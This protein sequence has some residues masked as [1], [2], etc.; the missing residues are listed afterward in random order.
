M[1]IKVN[2][3]YA[4]ATPFI[5][6]NGVYKQAAA[7][8][9]DGGVYQTTILADPPLFTQVQDV[10]VTEELGASAT[11]STTATYLG[12]GPIY[13]QWEF[14]VDIAGGWI[15]LSDISTSITGAQTDTVSYLSL[16]LSNDG[17]QVRC[18]ITADNHTV[19]TNAATLTVLQGTNVLR[20]STNQIDSNNDGFVDIWE[21]DYGRQDLQTNGITAVGS[22]N[23]HDT[24]IGSGTNY[25]TAIQDIQFSTPVTLHAVC[26]FDVL[27]GGFLLDAKQSTNNAFRIGSD[28]LGNFLIGKD[29]NEITI[30]GDLNWHV[31]TL[32]L[33]NGGTTVLID[34]VV[35]GTDTD[36]ANADNFDSIVLFADN[37]FNN[38]ATG[39]I[40]EVVLEPDVNVATQTAIAIQG[41]VKYGIL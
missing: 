7:F 25:M 36:P 29:R 30:P 26:K 6:V 17:I 21:D 31:I 16:D 14:Y 32:I 28:L 2:G 40:A 37:A 11:F 10:T 13:Y 38:N 24:A 5:K 20:Y 8:V 39:Q 41:A 34:G 35:S 3:G 12:T 22:L 19:I 1:H 27:D 18:V 33:S 23:G 15:P 4:P 9:K